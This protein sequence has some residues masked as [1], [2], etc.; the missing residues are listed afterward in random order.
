MGGDTPFVQTSA[1]T[2]KGIDE[3]LEAI[4]L[5][6]EL[7]ELKANPNSPATGTCLEAYKSEGEGVLATLLVQNGTL[8]RGDVVLCGAAYG[9][10]RAMYDDLRPAVAGSR[11]V[12]SRC[13]S[14]ASTRCP[15]P[16]TRSTSCRPG[17]RRATSPSDGQAQVRKRRSPRAAPVSLETLSEAK[18]TE[19]KIILKAEARGS[20]EAIRKELEKLDHAEVRVRIL[21]AAIGGITENDVWLALTSPQDTLI[22]GFNVVP[23]D[24]AQALAEERGVQIRQYNIIY[25]LTDDVRSALE[26]KLKPREEVVHLG[27]ASCA[28]RSR[29]ARSAPSPAATL[30][31]APSSAR[32]RCASFAA[33]W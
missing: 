11:P 9:R 22:I 6:A 18:I 24:R 33:A 16:T 2:G 3:L 30:P 23:D 28:R 26:G 7:R 19:L 14:P 13:A 31:R 29:S 32:P 21:E 12:A 5:V 20:I 17:H 8:Q 10:V 4:S 25:N 15:T 1:A 27:R